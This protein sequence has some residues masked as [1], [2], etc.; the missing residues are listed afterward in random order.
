MSFLIYDIILLITFAVFIFSF[1]YRNRKNLKKEGLL[2]LYKANWGIKLIE[3]VGKK[4]NKTLKVLSYVSII[5]GYLL[6]VGAVYLVGKIVWLYVLHPSIVRAIKIPPIMPLI[7]YLPQI[8][9]LNFLPP[10]YFTY[11]IIILAI[12]AIAHEFAHGVFASN[13]QVKTKTTGFGFFPFFL[14][15][16]L[17]AFVEL[18]EKIMAT[19]KKFSQMTI[20]SAGT[21]ANV[22]TGI[23]FFGIIFTF[24]SLT[25]SP[26]G[27]IFDDYSYS[28]ID[29]S[30]IIFVNNF[31]V[32]NPS[33]EDISKII[34]NSTF[35][36]IR[37]KDRSFVGIKDVS[38]DFT[39]IAL[40]D[41]S[42]AIHSQLV[43]AI[44][45]I[46]DININSLDKLTEELS[47][48]S[49]GDKILITIKLENET[50]NKEIILGENPDIKEKAWLG[51]RFVEPN[52]DSLFNKIMLKLSSFRKPNIYYESN[53]GEFGWFIYNLIWWTILISFSVAFVNMLPVGIFDGGRFFYL[54]IWGITKKEKLAKKIFSIMTYLFLGVLVL[55][56]VVWAKALL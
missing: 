41:N 38:E 13:N 1:L 5:L 43:G 34:Q 8:F 30:S 10:F 56:M 16:F 27:V 2:F 15:I 4:Y 49:P 11:W 22:L 36:D 14:P 55:L 26:A 44:T 6:M 24:F 19:K 45:K 50:Q 31:S 40:Y 18:D 17:A 3:G 42:P 7:P 51:I 33:Y 46:N 21:F 12:I 37:T 25:F 52:S 47:K 48:Y 32:S 9:K 28:V 23:L 35:N 29:I 39:K 20:L 53:L 54:T